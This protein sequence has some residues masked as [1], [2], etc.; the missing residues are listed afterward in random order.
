LVSETAHF[1]KQRGTNEQA[2]DYCKKSETQEK[3]FIQFGTFQAGR[4]KKGSR[5]DVHQLR[6]RIRQGATQRELIEDDTIVQTFAKYIKFADRV[7]TLYPPQKDLSDF[8]VSLYYGEPGGGKTTKAKDENPGIFDVPLS[9]GTL[10]LD[11]YDGHEVALLDDFAGKMSKISLT[12]TL[13]FLD[14]FP[15]QVPI[16]GG[17]VWWMPKHVIITTNIHPRAWYEWKGRSKH[18]QALKRRIHEVIVFEHGDQ[19]SIIP[20]EFLEDT[21]L[22][23]EERTQDQYFPA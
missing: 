14:R 23:P 20:E 9:N 22:W 3:E 2:R 8:K 13:R 6:D 7:R 4:A 21:D 12:N 19:N 17:F 16:K 15:V 11:G 5:N 18:W 10:W 1:E